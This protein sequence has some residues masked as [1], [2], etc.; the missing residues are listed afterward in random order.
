MKFALYKISSGKVLQWQDDAIYYY[1]DPEAGYARLELDENELPSEFDPNV[2]PT[3]WWVVDEELTTE[4][5]PQPSEDLA[6][7]LL[8]VIRNKSY[9]RIIQGVPLGNVPNFSP[10][11][12]DYARLSLVALTLDQTEIER[13]DIQLNGLRVWYQFDAEEVRTAFIAFVK[14]RELCKNAERDHIDAIEALRQADNRAALLAYDVGAKWPA[15]V[16]L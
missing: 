4:E 2:W 5:P 16:V 11:E 12:S 1:E 6:I 8:A 14:M 13:V 3:T 9:E 10:I 15:A 7:A